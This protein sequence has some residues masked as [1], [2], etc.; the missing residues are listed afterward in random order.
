MCFK[1]SFADSWVSW[2]WRKLRARTFV[3]LV[4]GIG[5]NLLP[6]KQIWNF[7]R[8]IR[9]DFFIV[10]LC[11][12]FSASKAFR[13]LKNFFWRICF[14]ATQYTQVIYCLQSGW[15]QFLS[16]FHQ[17]DTQGENLTPLRPH[18]SQSLLWFS[19]LSLEVVCY[20]SEFFVTVFII[21][22]SRTMAPRKVGE[23]RSQ[24]CP[25]F[26]VKEYLLQ[27]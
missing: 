21:N 26:Y 12:V 27:D 3:K 25:F 5:L 10:T 8:N 23:K 9:R 15:G 18:F 20:F 1:F 19:S 7:K 24:K 4:V 6:V 11:L 2:D 22:Y 17:I 13:F 14:N 16:F